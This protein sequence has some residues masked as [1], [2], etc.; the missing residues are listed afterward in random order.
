MR[1]QCWRPPQQTTPWGF[2][3]WRWSATPRC[4]TQTFLQ[5]H[6]VIEPRSL[7]VVHSLHKLGPSAPSTVFF[8][9]TL[10]VLS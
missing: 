4:E 5:M 6:T 10:M 8:V 1:Q 2:G 9:G 7:G 3:T